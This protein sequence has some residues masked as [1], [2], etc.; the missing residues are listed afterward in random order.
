MARA[1]RAIALGESFACALLDNHDVKCWGANGDG[2]LGQGDTQNRG[3]GLGAEAG[4]GDDLPPINLGA[5]RFALDVVAGDT[6]V[7][8]LL[9]NHDVKCWGDN[10]FGHLGQGDTMT[11][12]AGLP[13]D[14]GMG[15]GL[16]KVNLGTGRAAVAVAAGA[17][18]TCALLDNHD[19]KCWGSNGFGRLG[20]GDTTNRGDGAQADPGMGD[21]LPAV[22]LGLGRQPTQVSCGTTHTCATFDDGAIKCWGENSFGQLGQ[23]NTNSRGDGAEDDPGMGDNLLPI[24]L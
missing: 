9:D 20:L 21:D 3:L 5:G 2:Q 7:C 14:P 24:S 16:P 10:G 23:G 1:A 8:A 13:G 18:H 22:D 17:R 19:V 11:R 15:D 12:G 6:H 4:L